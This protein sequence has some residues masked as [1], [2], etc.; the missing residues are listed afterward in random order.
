MNTNREGMLTAT[1]VAVALQIFSASAQTI[2]SNVP[3]FEIGASLAAFVYQGDLTPSAAGSFRTMRPG[4]NLHGSKILNP[5]FLLRTNLAISGFKG[6]DALY[7]D[8]EYRKHRAFKFKSPLFELSE[9]I[10]WNPLGKN[11]DDRGLSPYLFAGIGVGFLK[12]KRDWSNFDAD[13]FGEESDLPARIQQDADHKTPKVI[14]VIPIGFGLRYGLSSRLA[15][16][17]ESS[18]RFS[19]TDYIDGFSQA[20]N[21]NRDDAYSSISIGAIYRIGKKNLL[22]CPKVTW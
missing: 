20:V 21:P 16:H 10:V 6:D 1:I 19:R 2:T 4:I 12:V 13:Y 7:D 22:D 3:K 14:P 11:Y 18:Y 15:V 5:S 17:A 8:P 9:L